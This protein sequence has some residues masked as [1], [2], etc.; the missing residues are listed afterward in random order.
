MVDFETENYHHM[1][2][3]QVCE[4]YKHVARGMIEV[5]RR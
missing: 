3:S 2:T 5:F 1:K 4:G